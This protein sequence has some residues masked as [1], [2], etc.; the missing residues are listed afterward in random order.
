MAIIRFG[1]G[2]IMISIPLAGM[3]HSLYL[4]SRFQT[5]SEHIDYVRK[6]SDRYPVYAYNHLRKLV[7][8]HIP[9]E[10]LRIKLE[11]DLKDAKG[12]VRLFRC[13]SVIQLILLIINSLWVIIR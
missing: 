10:L 4:L 5:L 12:K 11:R 8:R 2:L 7:G 1:L 9:D 6:I 13:F 3:I